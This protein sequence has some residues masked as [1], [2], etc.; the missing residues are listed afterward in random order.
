[1]TSFISTYV[2]VKKERKKSQFFYVIDIGHTG[3]SIN[4]MVDEGIGQNVDIEVDLNLTLGQKVN[5]GLFKEERE[6]FE[7][8]QVFS[9]MGLAAKREREVL[10]F[11]ELSSIE[12]TMTQFI[13]YFFKSIVLDL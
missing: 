12:E 8:G 5:L 1:M 9:G 6:E 3:G 11:L 10:D 7:H 4:S 2:M 13:F